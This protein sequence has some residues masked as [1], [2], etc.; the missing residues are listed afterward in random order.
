MTSPVI[1]RTEG[2]AVMT[3]NTFTCTLVDLT[4]M[5]NIESIRTRNSNMRFPTGGRDSEFTMHESALFRLCGTAAS[6]RAIQVE[7]VKPVVQTLQRP[8]HGLHRLRVAKGGP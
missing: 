6:S 4:N 8:G 1:R 2:V 7:Q 3:E 5:D